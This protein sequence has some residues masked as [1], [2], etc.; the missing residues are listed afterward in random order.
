MAPGPSNLTP[1]NAP[2]VVI[3]AAGQGT[4]MRSRTPKMLHDICCRPMIDWT[5]AAAVEAGAGKVVVVGSPDGALAGRLPDGVVLAVQPV[6][7]GT[8]GAVLAAAGELDGAGPVVV[9]NGDAP[10]VTPAAL[11]ALVDAHAESGAAATIVT[12]ML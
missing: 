4:R 5:V 2:T 7:N 10:L 1:V 9:V 3:L 11:G 6:A 12:M 8:G